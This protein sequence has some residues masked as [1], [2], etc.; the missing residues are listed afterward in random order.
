LERKGE[1]SFSFFSFSP[2]QIL[3][4][5]FFFIDFKI[6]FYHGSKLLLYAFPFFSLTYKLQPR[7]SMYQ[8]F[9]TFITKLI[10]IE[11]FF[12]FLKFM[13]LCMTMSY[14]P[15]VAQVNEKPS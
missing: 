1:A 4:K 5:P 6:L 12:P 15:Q 3:F 13:V 14:K 11:D 9:H 2:K 10:L 8:V 7:I